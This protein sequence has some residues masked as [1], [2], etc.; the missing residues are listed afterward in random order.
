MVE[1]VV[2]LDSWSWCWPEG[3]SDG[4]VLE[5]GAGTEGAYG[6]AAY[7]LLMHGE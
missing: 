6:D 1:G 7:K 5:A 4:F 2:F 3:E